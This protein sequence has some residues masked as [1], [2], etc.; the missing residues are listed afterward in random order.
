LLADDLSSFVFIFWSRHGDS[1]KALGLPLFI[2]IQRP[3]PQH[4]RKPEA[5]RL[6]PIEDLLH[7]FRREAGERQQPADVGVGD[8]LLLRKVGDR[9]GLTALDSPRWNQRFDDRLVAAWAS[10][11]P[12]GLLP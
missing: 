11:P 12:S 5:L 10:A 8:A 2:P 9:L 4:L 1:G 7:D 3:I 6:P